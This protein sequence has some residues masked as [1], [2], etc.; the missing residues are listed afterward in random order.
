MYGCG[1]V[2][3]SGV[4]GNDRVGMDMYASA[5][6]LFERERVGVGVS[7]RVRVRMGVSPAWDSTIKPPVRVMTC[8]RM[9]FILYA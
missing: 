6:M 3:G 4:D 2:V 8:G 1:S 7:V 5:R 9:T